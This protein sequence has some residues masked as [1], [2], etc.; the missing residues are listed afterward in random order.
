MSS[1]KKKIASIAHRLEQPFD[2]AKAKLKER[3][4]GRDPVCIKPYRGY[5]NGRDLYLQ[6]RVLEDEG[7]PP[8]EED[9]T[10]WQNVKATYKRFESDEIAG[11]VVRAWLESPGGERV[12]Q[13][14]TTDEEGYF[15]VHLQTTWD[16]PEDRVWHE[17]ELELLSGAYDFQ[18]EPVQATGRVL[19]PPSGARFGVISDMDDTVLQ[20]GATN[21]WQMVSLTLLRN[22]H[23]RLPFEGVAAFYR[24]LQHGTSQTPDN[25][26]FYVS[27]SP[28][29]LYELLTNFLDVH[30]IPRG[31]LFLRDL[32]I[33][34]DK[35][36]KSDHLEHK[37]AQIE[38]LL[39][40]YPDLPFILIGD[41]GQKDPEIYQQA[42]ED[43]PGR[44][45]A[46]YVRDVTTP[47]RDKEVHAIAQAVEQ[48]GVPMHLVKDTVAAAENAVERGLIS[49]D[50]LPDVRAEK[51]KDENAPSDVEQLTGKKA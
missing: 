47:A 37:L 19:V 4:G 2:R 46:I 33:D 31:P 13:E 23:T 18:K 28:W 11:A 50:S 17:V 30:G 42:V 39:S 26:V 1:R 35:F 48:R 7:T 41:S 15:D 16:L 6:G 14:A 32:G 8:A 10:A 3:V 21:L 36:I 44:I 29:N 25:P 49:E 34:Q 45:E 40:A 24:A 43:F 27:S 9:S 12:A 38:R 5:G 51:A 22:A 20:T